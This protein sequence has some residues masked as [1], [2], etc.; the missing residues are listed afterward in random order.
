LN[1]AGEFFPDAIIAVLFAVLQPANRLALNPAR[2]I[3][4]QEA[5]DSSD[6]VPTLML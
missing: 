6:N 2:I 3:F 5:V 4:R 1:S